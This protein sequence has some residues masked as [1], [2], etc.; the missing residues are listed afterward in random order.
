M[1][2][3][4]SVSFNDNAKAYQALSD[5]KNSVSSFTVLSARL[6]EKVGN[7]YV[8]KDGF[9]AD[10]Y[11]ENF[12]EGGMIGALIGILGGPLGVI[13]GGSIG[14]LIGSANDASSETKKQ[15]TMME[16][17]QDSENGLV[18]VLITQESSSDDLDEFL[19]KYDVKAIIR[20]DF[21]EVHRKILAAEKAQKQLQKDAHDE[22][23]AQKKKAFKKKVAASRNE[24]KARF[25]KITDGKN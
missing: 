6:I 2:N 22:V 15:D 23:I 17:A 19:Q 14:M 21:S 7:T 16:I 18:L 9:D 25:A 5:L 8:Q 10:A 11:G 13:L 12:A 3:V 20:E 4:V 1:E 24:I